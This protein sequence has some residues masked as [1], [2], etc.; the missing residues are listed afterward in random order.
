MLSRISS[1]ELEVAAVRQRLLADVHDV[2]EKPHCREMIVRG[3]FA[4]DIVQYDGKLYWDGMSARGADG[5]R[6]VFAA[7]LSTEFK[8]LAKEGF[9]GDLSGT[10]LDWLRYSRLRASIDGNGRPGEFVGAELWQQPQ[11]LPKR[12]ASKRT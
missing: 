5:V 10:V 2:K 9:W 8:F 6:R 1:D 3:G 4:P 12:G 11:R 7:P